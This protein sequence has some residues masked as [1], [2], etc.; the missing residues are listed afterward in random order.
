M[1]TNFAVYTA[2]ARINV[3]SGKV[4]LPKKKFLFFPQM[5]VLESGCV[6]YP[7]SS[8]YCNTNIKFVY[9]TCALNGFILIS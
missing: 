1:V 7:I 9:H 5:N 2:Q 4:G 3:S 8:R 6:N